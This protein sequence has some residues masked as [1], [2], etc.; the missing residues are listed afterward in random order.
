VIADECVPGEA[1]HRRL[2]S[3]CAEPPR[4]L[5]MYKPDRQSR[6]STD[7]LELPIH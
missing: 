1:D 6:V 7:R 5:Y 4:H 2:H 3:Q